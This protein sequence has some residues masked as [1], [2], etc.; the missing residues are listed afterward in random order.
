MMVDRAV[1]VSRRSVLGM[2]LAT[3][4]TALV[5]ACGQAPATGTP[6]APPAAAE[7]TRPVG[8]AA[9]SAQAPATGA[10][11]GTVTFMVP[12]G[13]QEDS[14]FQPV[15]DEFAK[16][17]PNVKATY[18]GAGTGYTPQYDDKLLTMLAGNTAPDVFKTLQGNFGALSERG[19]YRDLDPYVKADPTVQVDDF[20]APHMESCRYK[21]K[22]N[23]LPNDGAPQG[24]WYNV[25]LFKKENVALPDWDWDWAKLL[26]ASKALTKRDAGGRATSFGLGQPSWLPWVWSNGGDMLDADGKTCLL[27]KREAVEA[28]SWIQDRAIKDRVIPSPAELTEMNAN[29]MF[30]SGRL[31]TSFGPRGSLGA[32]RNIK[33]F[34]FDAAPLI[35]GKKRVSLMGV[36][37]TSIWSGSKAPDAAFVLT[38]WVCSAEGQKLRISRGF[39]HP[40]RQSLVTQDWYVNYKADKSATNGINTVFSETLK[41]GEARV[42]PAHPKEKEI[43]V[44]INKQLDSL[45]DGKKPAAQIAK[46]IA[47]DVNKI[48]QS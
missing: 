25:D 19:A 47:A 9:P 42:W 8:G 24:T 21:G 7:P 4:G 44:A 41:R 6:T 13:Q 11:T 48:L 17:F 16:R 29:D 46:D 36:G 34:T 31:A 14:D 20:F 38:N 43:T 10:A 39:A 3:L 2:G 40:S 32:F 12:G 45:W 23:A 33:N 30:T 1:R 26:D 5:A 28:F 27:D 15:F 37:W 22:L 18:T 35:K